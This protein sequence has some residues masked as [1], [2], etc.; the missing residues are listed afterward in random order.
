MN[1]LLPFWSHAIAAACFVALTVWRLRLP[2]R[3]RRDRLLI[4]AYLLTAAWAWLSAIG[5]PAA[6]LAMLAETLR[7]FAWIALLHSLS[8]TGEEGLAPP[9]GLRL[10]YAAQSLVIGMQLTL[11]F[12]ALSDLKF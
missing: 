3:D 10:L 12:L 1:A 9:R 4:A 2:A 11:N 5:G 6:P 7:N 8:T